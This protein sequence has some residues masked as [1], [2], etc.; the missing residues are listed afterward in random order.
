MFFRLGGEGL[1]MKRSGRITSAYRRV[2]MVSLIVKRL[3]RLVTW[4]VFT[5]VLLGNTII[6][7]TPCLLID[8]IRSCFY[9]LLHTS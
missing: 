2:V 6:V 4:L 3:E 1:W 8:N 7:S 5:V 9:V